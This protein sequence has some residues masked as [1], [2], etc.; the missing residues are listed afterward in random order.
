MKYTNENIMELLKNYNELQKQVSAFV[1]NGHDKKLY[2]WDPARI[3]HDNYTI[4]RKTN[5]ACNCHP[6]YEWETFSTIDLFLE[7]YKKIVKVA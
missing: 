1:N 3:N 4:E 7:W 5:T 2:S 6:E